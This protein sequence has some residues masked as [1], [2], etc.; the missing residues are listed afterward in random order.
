M[1]IALY[2][3]ECQWE[4]TG[5]NLARAGRWIASRQA[6][7]F[8]LPEM[9]STGFSMSPGRV[10]EPMDGAS[11][12]WMRETACR[13]DAAIGGSLAIREKDSE[14]RTRFVNRFVFAYPDGRIDWYDKRHLFRMGGERDSYAAGDRR[15]V[16]EFRGWRILLLVCYDL[17]F[18]VW[19]R[20]R[21]D[22]DLILYTADWP[23]SRS[24]AWR[25]LLAA[26]AIENQCYVAG[27]NRVGSDPLSRYS[28]DSAV[29]DFRG[30]IVA[31]GEPGCEQLVCAGI[32]RNA[33]LAFRKKFPAWLD[34]DEFSV[35]L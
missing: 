9:F 19:A 26:R 8:V 25:T 6:D 32:D 18:P 13:F 28:G 24:A 5:A 3:M 12:A 20:N 10:A 4:D 11:V 1:Q 29:F 16:V 27:V 2:Q 23:A 14:G 35:R 17:R 34:A 22:Y 30:E 21:G 33:L 15:V 31:G 7:L